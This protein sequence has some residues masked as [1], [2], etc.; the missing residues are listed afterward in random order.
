MR[1]LGS[2]MA[3]YDVSGRDYGH[4]CCIVYELVRQALFVAAPKR[5]YE[6]TVAGNLKAEN[7]SAAVALVADNCVRLHCL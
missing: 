2:D 3:E 6:P 5:R 7:Q 1:L 4:R